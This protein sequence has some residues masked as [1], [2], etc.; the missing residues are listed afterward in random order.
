MNGQETTTKS[1]KFPLEVKKK[2][3]LT[4]NFVQVVNI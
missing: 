3:E 1:E 2:I 4:L